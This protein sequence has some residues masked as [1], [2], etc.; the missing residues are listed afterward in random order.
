[1][2][3]IAGILSSRPVSDDALVSLTRMTRAI[4][5]RGPDGEGYWSNQA[6]GVAFGHRRLAVI[7]L[8]NRAAQ[9]MTSSDGRF[10]ITF[11]GEIYNHRQLKQQLDRQHSID[12]QSESDTE[13]LLEAIRVWG[14]ESTLDRVEGMFALGLYDQKLRSVILARDRFGEKPCYL[15]RVDSHTL[16][17]GSE[18]RCIEQHPA[19]SSRISTAALDRYVQ[20]GYVPAPLCIYEDVFK[21]PAGTMLTVR[22]QAL[23]QMPRGTGLLDSVTRFWSTRRRYQSALNQRAVQPQRSSAA[24]PS[25]D[26]QRQL[27][28]CLTD[29]VGLR[30]QADV[31]A[32]IF[33]SGGIDSSL[34]TALAQQQSGRPVSTF[35]IGIDDPSIA[36]FAESADEAKSA[37]R[38]AAAVG[39]DHHEL[40][41]S[42]SDA[43]A[44]VEKL[45][46]IY[47]EPFADPSQIPT[48]IVASFASEFVKVAL[49]GDGADEAFAGYN[50]HVWIHQS[51][52]MLSRLPPALRRTASL[53]LVTIS[54]QGWNRLYGHAERLIP[55][56]RKVTSPGEKL[57]KLA[58]ALGVG[59]GDL[60]T[61]YAA[62]IDATTDESLLAGSRHDGPHEHHTFAAML[63]GAAT[64]VDQFMLWDMTEY[65]S[66]GLLTKVDRASMHYGL[67]VRLP[68]LDSAV[69]EHAM[70]LPPAQKISDSSGKQPLRR[71]LNSHVPQVL[72]DRPKTGFSI[73]LEQWLRADL[74]DWAEQLLSAH[75]LQQSPELDAS[76]IRRLWH[77]HK[78]GG[79]NHARLLWHILMYAAWKEA[80]QSAA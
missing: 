54:Q 63:S 58:G 34:L 69:I 28:H 30:L 48:A 46:A 56:R 14:L 10:I 2:C 15:T 43:R 11:N 71:L 61:I 67:E 59:E 45:P 60:R 44:T 25:A 4:A 38:V 22:P 31:A 6:H 52:P 65:L 57:H 40:Y 49:A 21:L 29:S 9:P 74:K 26:K 41:L 79:A 64:D 77:E 3:G 27:Q 1:M 37:A 16:L 55:D 33:L 73:P 72:V 13:V 76:S 8:S 19:F 18:L 35:S 42:G 23:A 50:R 70:Q 47:D 62:L 32:G 78:S 39:T 53:L 51:W 36:H 5:H 7:D 75:S 24:D 66:H 12:W 68:Y 80:R 20:T 17:F